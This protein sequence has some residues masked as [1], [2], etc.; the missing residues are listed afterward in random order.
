MTSTIHHLA[1]S[2]F[3]SMG[4]SMLVGQMLS[5]WHMMSPLRTSRSRI[6]MLITHRLLR[7]AALRP[8]S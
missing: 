7:A 6:P 4:G 2:E 3:S 8:G 1:G 5:E